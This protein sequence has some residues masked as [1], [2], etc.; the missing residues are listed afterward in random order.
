MGRR[1]DVQLP[2]RFLKSLK[3][4][5]SRSLDLSR[6]QGNLEVTLEVA[7]KNTFR[8]RHGGHPRLPY[9]RV[10]DGAGA[11]SILGAEI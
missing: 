6:E 7:L 2:K 8:N 10:A 4:S 1:V 9:S 5:S 11:P 3:S